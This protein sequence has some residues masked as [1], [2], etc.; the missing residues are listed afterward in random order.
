MRAPS[1]PFLLAQAYSFVGDKEKTL[2]YL[3]KAYQQRSSMMVQLK[4]H[5][6]FDGVRSEARFQ[7]LLRNMRLDN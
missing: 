4:V 5:S 1:N 3:E 7:Q 2:D 6:Y